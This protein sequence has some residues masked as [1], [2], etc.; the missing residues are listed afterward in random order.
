[1]KRTVRPTILYHPG[2]CLN[3]MK[4]T[5]NNLTQY[6][7]SLAEIRTGPLPSMG[8]KSHSS[9][10][11]E[12]GFTQPL[13]EMSTRDLPGRKK[14]LSCKADNLTALYEWIVYKMWNSRRLT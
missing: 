2:I 4:T 12:L 3:G 14:G 7:R 11:M 8:Q 9:P 13:T 5:T 1:V 6:N 10:S